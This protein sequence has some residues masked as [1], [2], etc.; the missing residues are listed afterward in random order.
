MVKEEEIVKLNL[1]YQDFLTYLS[2][3]LTIGISFLVAFLS[4]EI[5]SWVEQEW[6]NRLTL[7]IIF[8]SIEVIFIAVHF[9]IYRK[10]EDIKKDIIRKVKLTK[11]DK[12][13]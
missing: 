11:G 10:K 7:I 6:S 8:F 3:N 2:I 5:V 4:Y 1:N 13:E 12:N 9:W